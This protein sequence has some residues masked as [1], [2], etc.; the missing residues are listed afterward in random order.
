MDVL[1]QNFCALLM[2]IAMFKKI[3]TKAW[4][5]AVLFVVKR[6]TNQAKIVEF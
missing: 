3:V 2:K 6:I 5:P 1:T 4:L